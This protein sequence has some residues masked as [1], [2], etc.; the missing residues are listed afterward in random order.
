MVIH[1]IRQFSPA[2][3]SPYTVHK[4]L[5]ILKFLNQSKRPAHDWFLEIAFVHDVCMHVCVCVSAPRLL[6]TSGMIG[7]DMEPLC[8][9]KQ[10][11]S[12]SLLFIWAVE[13]VTNPY[14]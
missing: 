9:V 6:I 3:V 1:Q 2:N 13:V 8:L 4:Y 5:T 11:L 12:F 14:N 7:C 10:T